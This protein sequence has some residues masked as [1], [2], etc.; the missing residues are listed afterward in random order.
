MKSHLHSKT[1]NV[2]SWLA[3]SWKIIKIWG[4]SYREDNAMVNLY[5]FQILVHFVESL[6]IA[7]EDESSMGIVFF[8]S[9]NKAWKLSF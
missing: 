3:K 5:T 9:F 7:H 4:F 1:P 2:R 6:A 8:E